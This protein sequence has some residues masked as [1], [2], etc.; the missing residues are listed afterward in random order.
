MKKVTGVTISARLKRVFAILVSIILLSS[1]FSLFSFRS[2]GNNMTTFFQIQYDTTKKQ[3][4]IRKDVQTINKRILWAIIRKEDSETQKQREDTIKRFDKISQY[5]T[6]INQNLNNQ[7]SNELTTAFDELKKDTLYLYDIL[8]KGDAE[9]A[10]SYYETTFNEVSEVLA[11]ALDET[12]RQSDL[13]AENKYGTSKEVQN[14]AEILLF[15]L[16]AASLLIAILMGKR[17]IKSIAQPLKEMEKAA[18]EIAQGN[19]HTVITY[20]SD[21]EIGQAAQGLRT[22]IDKLSSYISEIDR[23]MEEMAGGNFNVKF[24]HEFSGDFRNIQRSLTLFTEKISTSFLE[25]SD[26]SRRVS[27]GSE[28][29]S[30]SA[31]NLA[32]G[33][34]SQAGIVRELSQT[35]TDISKKISENAEASSEIKREV[36]TV[37]VDITNENEAMNEM[38]LAMK[39]IKK[40]SD[41]ISKMIGTIGEIAMQTNLLALNASI[42][43]ARAGE[44]GKG[45]SVVANQV[46]L[47]A[48]Q[49]TQAA[50]SSSQLIDAS[51]KA[52]EEGSIIADRVSVKL[53]GVLKETD[54]ICTKISSMAIAFSQQAEAVKQVDTGIDQIAQVV[55]VNAAT[56][57]ENSAASEE[58]TSQ[59]QELKTLMAQFQL[60]L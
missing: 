48:N 4:E 47:L 3:M 5:I 8:E 10:F 39:T 52:V 34:E 56:A 25:I 58:L 30:E 21:D 31:Q 23:V 57:E 33:A 7:N 55:D 6:V 42:E 35:V 40:T 37:T 36:D 17:L 49:S 19:L 38:V 45:F 50:Q 14:A 24:I 18:N 12:G 16:S 11:D 41:E 27:E 20:E 26:G 59:A 53:K 43:A 28:Q 1:V 32:E 51:Q 9:G 60:K 13:D 46:S 29:I 22:S 44:A 54:L 2:I 15:L